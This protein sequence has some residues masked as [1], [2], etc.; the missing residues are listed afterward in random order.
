MFCATRATRVS[1]ALGRLG[2]RHASAAPPDHFALLRVERRFDLDSGQL[3]GSYKGLMGDAHP[4]RHGRASAEEQQRVADHAASITD[5][6]AV[7]R[8]PHLRA[9]HLLEL[10]GAPLDE[11]TSSDVLGAGF[12]ME[13]MEAR[14]ELEEAAGAEDAPRLQALRDAN[15]DAVGALHAA[16]GPAFAGG[17]LEQARA[18]TAR[19]QYLQRIEAEIRERLPGG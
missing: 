7:L 10:L 1:R 4:D 14:E 16:L 3:K 5:A 2:R 17:D 6:Y 18:L 13:V 9:V 8:E 12:L 15:R 11:E 19:L